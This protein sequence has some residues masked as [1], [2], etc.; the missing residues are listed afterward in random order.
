M[1]MASVALVLCILAKPTAAAM[2]SPNGA[3]ARGPSVVPHL[4]DIVP[5]TIY[6]RMKR[7]I[8]NAFISV[9]DQQLAVDAVVNEGVQEPDVAAAAVKEL[10][11]KDL[12]VPS[13]G[14][15]RGTHESQLVRVLPPSSSPRFGISKVVT[16]VANGT[17][18]AAGRSLEEDKTLQQSGLAFRFSVGKEWQKESTWLPLA[19]RQK[20][21]SQLSAL[22]TE[23]WADMNAAQAADAAAERK[24]DEEA[25][26]DMGNTAAALTVQYL[27]RITF[28]FGYRKGDLQK[29]TSFSV[30]AYYSPEVKPGVEL[31]F[32]WSEHRPYNP[33]RAVTLCSI[34][35]VLASMITVLAVL[36]PSSRSALLFSQRIVSVR[37]HD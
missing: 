20:Y 4:G 36:H 15:F 25:A 28:L 5:L 19:A 17:L 18:R 1:I 12:Y 22:L 31:Q 24:R 6:V 23:R 21:I 8:E 35:A 16:I 33:N 37:A 7:Q 13:L 11:L 9:F 14:A 3:V 10:G 29:M 32:L 26:D 30:K 34:V 2:L 27:S